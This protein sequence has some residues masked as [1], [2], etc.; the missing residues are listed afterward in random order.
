MNVGAFL[1]ELRSDPDYSGQIVHVSERP[2]RGIGA[3]RPIDATYGKLLGQIGLSTLY[4]HQAEAIR[5][6]DRGRDVLIASGTSSGKTLCYALPV[7][8]RLVESSRCRALMLFPTKALSQDQ[9]RSFARILPNVGLGSR[10]CGVYDGDTSPALR[11]RLRDAG[12]VLF[13]NPDMLHAGIMPQRQRR[14][15]RDYGAP[16]R[17]GNRHDHILEV[18]DDG[19][20]DLSLPAHGRHVPGSG[21]E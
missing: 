18:E 9:Y 17:T 19:R 20:D 3:A 10:L 14:G 5:L 7:V 2:P 8:R 6:I 16:R 12:S 15:P 13:S 11:R 4:R 1:S 21:L